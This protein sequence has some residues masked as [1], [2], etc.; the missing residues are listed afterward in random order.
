ML[1]AIVAGERRQAAPGQRGQCPLCAGVTIAKC[2]QRDTWHW[3]HKSA[4]CDPW[5]EFEDDWHRAW[6]SLFPIEWQEV[7][8]F[9][10]TSGEKHIADIRSSDGRVIEFQSSAIEPNEVAAREAFYA[11]M[12][13]IVDGTRNEFD[14]YY[15]NISIMGVVTGTE[16]SVNIS[17]KGR[18]KL[19]SRWAKSAHVVYLDFGESAL[20]RIERYNNF[21]KRGVATAVD[22]AKLTREFIEGCAAVPQLAPPR[23]HGLLRRALY[24]IRSIRR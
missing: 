13:W 11:P 15:F 21:T 3:A 22:K 9:D 1:I 2:G 19:L 18:G 6:K 14:R 17:W 16:F 24:S 23:P 10:A 20:W 4:N 8:T 12:I 5:H 7:I